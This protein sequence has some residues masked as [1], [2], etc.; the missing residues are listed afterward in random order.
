MV[1]KRRS[2]ANKRWAMQM[3]AN[4]ASALSAL[5][6]DANDA[7]IHIHNNNSLSPRVCAYG[8]DAESIGRIFPNAKVGDHRQLVL[9]IIEAVERE[10][11]KGKSQVE[12]L[13][14]VRSGTQNYANAMAG[15]P[16]KFLAK[17]ED[18]YGKGQ[19]NFDPEV[20]EHPEKAAGSK[21]VLHN[22]PRFAANERG[23]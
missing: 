1:E 8:D 22:N 18:F 10:I 11:D 12:A 13:A 17:P 4:D 3:D 5:Q 16:K 7:H 20:W 19:Y 9:T 21:D 23:L 15:K 14:V 6:A 2:A